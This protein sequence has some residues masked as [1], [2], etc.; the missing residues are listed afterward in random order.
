MPGNA[1]AR[2]LKQSW[3]LRRRSAP[4]T[5]VVPLARGWLVALARMQERWRQRQAL[6]DLDDRL[7]RDIGLTRE[8][9]DGEAHKPFWL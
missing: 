9:A 1:R 4:A 6:R 8:Q 2:Y 3:A 5:A 7:L